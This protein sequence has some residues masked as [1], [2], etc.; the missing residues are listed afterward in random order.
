MVSK[1]SDVRY[2]VYTHFHPQTKEI[3][4]VTEE[5]KN[6]GTKLY[7]QGAANGF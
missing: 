1:A 4:Y 6:A 5:H 7:Q 2:Y 3:V